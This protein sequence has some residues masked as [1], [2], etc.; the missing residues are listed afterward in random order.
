[1][2]VGNQSGMTAMKDFRDDPEHVRQLEQI[3]LAEDAG[4]LQSTPLNIQLEVTTLDPQAQREAHERAITLL[5]K[6]HDR[7]EAITRIVPA[8]LKRLQLVGAAQGFG[9]IA[10]LYDVGTA[11]LCI[12]VFSNLSV[13]VRTN[14]EELDANMEPR[15][16]SESYLFEPQISVSVIHEYIRPFLVRLQGALV[17]EKIVGLSR[18]YDLHDYLVDQAVEDITAE[19]DAR[20]LREVTRSLRRHYNKRKAQR[21]ARCGR[22]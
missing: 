15:L 1:M 6:V 20:I 21:R 7:Y 12:E 4:K 5:Q 2:V 19:E 16:I 3:M 22:R 13:R 14:Y 10:V 9:S 17:A 8:Q 11:R 18:S